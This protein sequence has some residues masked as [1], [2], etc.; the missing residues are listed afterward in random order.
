[1]KRKKNVNKMQINKITLKNKKKENTKK[2]ILLYF[3][4][5]S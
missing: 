5:L 2:K 1:M 4:L 3:N